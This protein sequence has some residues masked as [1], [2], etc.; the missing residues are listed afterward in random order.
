LLLVE[1]LVRA[2]HLGGDPGARDFPTFREERAAEV[3]CAI[4]GT[5]FFDLRAG[6]IAASG[7]KD[8]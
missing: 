4:D 3:D 6:L 7:A 2:K 8:A 1:L 5:G